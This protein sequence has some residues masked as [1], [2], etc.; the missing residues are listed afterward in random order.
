MLNSSRT[1]HHSPAKSHFGLALRVRD[2]KSKV[3]G[4]TMGNHS[5]QHVRKHA[6]SGKFPIIINHYDQ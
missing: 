2:Y 6:R 4:T 1:A 5:E 3:V